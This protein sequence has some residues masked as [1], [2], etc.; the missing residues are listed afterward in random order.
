MTVID[1]S[2]ERAQTAVDRVGDSFDRI[3]AVSRTPRP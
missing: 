1:D 2:L 3:E